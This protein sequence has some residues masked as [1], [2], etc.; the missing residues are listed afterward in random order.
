MKT[1]LNV[2]LYKLKRSKIILTTTILTMFAIFQG[3]DFATM[4]GAEEM[5]NRF[6]TLLYQGSMSVYSWLILPL[7]ITVVLA[8]M[9]RME[10]SNNNWKQL[11]ALPVARG[12]VYASKLLVGMGVIVYSLVL[13]YVGIILAAMVLGMD[14]IPFWWMAKRFGVLFL[15]TFTIIG[16]IF[17]MSYRFTHFG[18]PMV[19]GAGLAFPAMFVANSEKYWI[20]YPWDYP[21]VSSMSDILDMGGKSFIMLIVSI[22]LFLLAVFMGFLR[23]RTK[24]VL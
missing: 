4:D 15:S 8:M 18:V 14:S 7:I 9:A 11:L 3:L 13:L 22:S 1:L 6:L 2:E 24:D 20:Y 21:V 5:E 16:V 19:I 12:K 10:H 23:F 17:Y